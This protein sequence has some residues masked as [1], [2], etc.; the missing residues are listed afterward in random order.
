MKIEIQLAQLLEVILQEMKTNKDF[1][2]KIRGIFNADEKSDQNSGKWSRT[3][4]RSL[5]SNATANNEDAST[6]SAIPKKRSRKRNAALLNPETILEVQGE[7]VLL[8]S[9]NQ[10]EVD[11]LKDIVS[12]FGM[13]PGKKVM[14][15]KKKEKILSHIV[16]VANNR[17]QKG[18]AFR[19]I[20]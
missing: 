8:E 6:T 14:R 5:S 9:L 2:E 18:K 7:A 13:D 3:E 1:A 16:G 20:H 17:I 15:W 19:K 4:N 12:E 11:Q 10:L